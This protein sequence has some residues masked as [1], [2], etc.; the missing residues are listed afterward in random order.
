[1]QLRRNFAQLRRRR[2]TDWLLLIEAAVWLGLARVAIISLS[3]RRITRLFGLSPGGSL[4][5]SVPQPGDRIAWALGAVAPR[6]PWKST[7][8]VKALAGSC[9]LRLRG[10]P[11]SIALGVAKSESTPDGI[12]A[13]AWLSSGG[14]CITGGAEREGYRLLAQYSLGKPAPPD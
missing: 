4:E 11:A 10:I 7:C 3:F 8:L 2:R 6:T 1:M 5:Q 9:M 12:A 14:V 13:H